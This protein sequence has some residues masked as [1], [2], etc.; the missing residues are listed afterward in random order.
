MKKRICLAG[1][2][3]LL[4]GA[5]TAVHAQDIAGEQAQA[6]QLAASNLTTQGINAEQAKQLKALGIKILVPGYI[7]KGYRL[8]GVFAENRGGGPG[9]GPSYT[10]SY[11]S[12]T[13]AEMFAV[14][15]ASSGIG[16][17]PADKTQ[18]VW[19]GELGN[20]TVLTQM[21]EGAKPF[22]MTDWIGKGPFYQVTS[23]AM[24]NRKLMPQPLAEA[25]FLKIVKSLT[26]LSL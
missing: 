22:L 21:R 9:G 15:A 18:K 26:T 24:V 14:V 8:Y 16:S 19:N 3:L 17:A 11:T 4:I 10:I 23:P 2:G 12:E 5:T 25:E 20:I 6:F 13:T 7:P 1:V